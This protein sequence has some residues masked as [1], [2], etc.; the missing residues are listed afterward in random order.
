MRVFLATILLASCAYQPSSFSSERDP[1]RGQ[2]ATA[3]CLDV[4]VERQ[5]AA[6]AGATVLAYG[7]GNRCDRPVIV[8][9]AS[10]NV[11]GRRTDGS[12]VVLRPYDPRREIKPLWLDGRSMGRE[13]LAYETGTDFVDICVDVGSIARAQ[14]SP[15]L[16]FASQPQRQEVP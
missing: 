14:V 10:A 15:W 3:D 7:F 1:F 16:C 8:D 12:S 13:A 11:I 6:T 9:L 4:A 5:H 2:R